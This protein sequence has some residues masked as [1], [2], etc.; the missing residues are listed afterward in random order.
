MASIPTGA[1]QEPLLVSDRAYRKWK[2]NIFGG[3]GRWQQN[4]AA[5]RR[6]TNKFNSC[7]A[8]SQWGRPAVNFKGE[9]CWTKKKGKNKG[10]QQCISIETGAPTMPVEPIRHTAQIPGN[11]SQAGLGGDRGKAIGMFENL[12][13]RMLIAGAIVLLLVLR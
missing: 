4:H 3:N 6:D 1:C 12:D 13:K 5:H 10:H 8:V 11:T 7:L 2:T 9:T